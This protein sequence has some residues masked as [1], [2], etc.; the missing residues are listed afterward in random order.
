V[1]NDYSHFEL[2]VVDLMMRMFD[3]NRSGEINLDQ[4]RKLWNFLGSW[5]SFFE[6]QDKDNSGHIDLNEFTACLSQMGYS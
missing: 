1:N 6:A 5:R 3:A 4:F 2:N